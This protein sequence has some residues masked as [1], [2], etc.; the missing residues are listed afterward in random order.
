MTH[1]TDD[2]RDLERLL[3]EVRAEIAR[4][5]SIGYTRDRD[6]GLTTAEWV[7]NLTRQ[8]G[9]MAPESAAQSLAGLS[10]PFEHMEYAR[11]HRQLIR[12]AALALAAAMTLPGSAERVAGAHTAGAGF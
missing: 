3:P 6:L 2:L 12:V 1:D 8:V 10:S 7:S 11:V 5:R 4:Q 9:L